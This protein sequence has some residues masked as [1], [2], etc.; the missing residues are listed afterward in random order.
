MTHEEHA[1]AVIAHLER[2]FGMAEAD[3]AKLMGEAIAATRRQA[4][5][6]ALGGLETWIN[7]NRPHL[8]AT[9]IYEIRRRREELKG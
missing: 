3:E 7:V 1:M 4:V 9:V 6:E 5:D 8:V 2:N